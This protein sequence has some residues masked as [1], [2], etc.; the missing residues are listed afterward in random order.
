[1]F[2]T[3]ACSYEW[4]GSKIQVGCIGCHVGLQLPGVLA[5]T[6]LVSSYLVM[7]LSWVTAQTA[8]GFGLASFSRET[9]GI[10]WALLEP[11][12]L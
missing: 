10:E 7:M 2:K 9:L 11:L 8:A 6:I 5:D 4:L 1:M 12:Q 3:G